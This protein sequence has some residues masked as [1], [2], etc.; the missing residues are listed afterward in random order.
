M[1]QRDGS[2]ARACVD[3]VGRKLGAKN[4][5]LSEEK[6]DESTLLGLDTLVLL[7]VL[8]VPQL[9]GRNSIDSSG[10]ILSA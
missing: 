2:L 4:M 8:L 9:L 7:S 5:P 3:L 1:L 6:K 10:R